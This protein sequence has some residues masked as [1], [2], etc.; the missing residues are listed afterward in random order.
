MLPIFNRAL[1]PYYLRYYGC[2][3]LAI[4]ALALSGCGTSVDEVG[5]KEFRLTLVNNTDKDLI[6]TFRRAIADF[7]ESAG[8]QALTYVD[9]PEQA[10]SAI[11]ITKG[12]QKRDGKVG[13]GQPLAEI[14]EQRR[15]DNLNGVKVDRTTRHFM[16]VEFDEEYIR[17][18]MA[19]TE[20][21]AKYDLKKLFSH[22]V[23][24]GFEM[25]H[26]MN[27]KNNLMFP[28]IS[29]QKNFD[30]YFK[31]VRLYFN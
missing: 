21:S 11:V 17:Q 4:L 14:D 10:N 28:D 22:E 16:R 31:N 23:G 9:A 6:N 20:E 24:H 5:V 15:L 1:V 26:E 25:G 19:S 3:S 13:W 18:R 30:Q 8:M 12:L 2:L 29:G 27:D 7:N